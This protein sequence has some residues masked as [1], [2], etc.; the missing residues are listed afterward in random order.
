MPVDK[1][2]RF[3]KPDRTITLEVS[4]KNKADGINYAFFNDISYQAPQVPTLFT[5]LN[6]NSTAVLDPLTY[7]NMTNPF[8]IKKGEVVDII[9]KNFDTGA[10]PLHLHGHDFQVLYRSPADTPYIP[11][12]LQYPAVPMRRDTVI[13]NQNG[14][15]V[16]RFTADNP[17]IWLFHCH[18]EWHILQGLTSTFLEAPAELKRLITIPNDQYDNCRA[19]GIDISSDTTSTRGNQTVNGFAAPDS[20]PRFVRRNRA[21]SL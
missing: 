10:H 20:P 19:T 7:G 14:S 17:G 2:P 4:F 13:I 9:I 18:I 8:I 21:I 1:T 5:A 11:T 15:L 3:K 12:G 16:L 6:A